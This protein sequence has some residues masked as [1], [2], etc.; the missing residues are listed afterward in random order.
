M[1]GVRR[2]GVTS[3]ASALQARGLIRYQ[4]GTLEILERA[5]LERAS[6]ECYRLQLEAYRQVLK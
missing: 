2:P 6:C 1:L 5:G 3:A 4:R